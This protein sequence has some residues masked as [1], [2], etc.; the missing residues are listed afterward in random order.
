LPGINI[1]TLTMNREGR[2]PTSLR[3]CQRIAVQRMSGEIVA[4]IP[5]PQPIGRGIRDALQ[6]C[7]NGFAQSDARDLL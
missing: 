1:A 7:S 4:H 6:E 5:R 3:Q 2:R